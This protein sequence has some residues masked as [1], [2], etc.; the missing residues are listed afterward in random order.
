MS[1]LNDLR[2]DEL[3]DITSE[4]ASSTVA[5]QIKSSIIYLYFMRNQYSMEIE[6]EKC[7]FCGAPAKYFQFAAFISESNE[8]MEKAMTE[9]G[10]PAGHKKRKLEMMQ[11]ESSK[12]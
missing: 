1:D 11:Q 2:C 9:R 8:C 6:E 5:D 12:Q 7:Q 4:A 10:G 3:R